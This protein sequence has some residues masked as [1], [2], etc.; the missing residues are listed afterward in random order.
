MSSYRLLNDTKWDEIRVAMG[1]LDPAPRWRTKDL[2]N[3]HVSAWDQ[4]WF[5][6]FREGGYACIEWLEIECIDKAMLAAVGK[7]LAQVHVPGEKLSSG[8]RVY[9]HGWPG[10][11]YDYI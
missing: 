4:E 9:G 11:S 8:F 6:H 1:M 10:D 5:Y 3:D 7:A 2:E